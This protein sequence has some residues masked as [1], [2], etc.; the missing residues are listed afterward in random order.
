MTSDSIDTLAP[1]GRTMSTSWT[2]TDNAKGE[3]ITGKGVMA[4][5]SPAPMGAH[6]TSGGWRRTNDAQLSDQVLTLM[7][8]MDG[9]ALTMT[10]PTGE[11]YT[12][13]VGG[14]MVPLQGDT[15]N[16]MVKV[17][18]GGPMTLVE[19]DYR[20]GKPVSRFTMIAQPGGKTM[21]FIGTDLKANATS[22]FTGI[23]Q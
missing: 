23:R 21:K 7:L 16:T 22:E 8:K 10:Q 1:D 17:T 4:R 13:V 15:A 3:T 14:A 6:A 12:A 19:T 11:T 9:N 20:G 2:T 18:R 5:T